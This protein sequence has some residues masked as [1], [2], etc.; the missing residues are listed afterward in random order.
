M[1]RSSVPKFIRGNKL[2][3]GVGDTS[4][5]APLRQP[6]PRPRSPQSRQTVPFGTPSGESHATQWAACYRRGI[7]VSY[8]INMLTDAASFLGWACGAQVA[9]YFANDCCSLRSSPPE[10]TN[11][12]TYTWWGGVGDDGLPSFYHRVNVMLACGSSCPCSGQISRHFSRL[13]SGHPW[14]M[15]KLSARCT[16]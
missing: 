12:A 3:D 1:S 6:P 15:R 10:P 7:K 16:R 11:D 9:C 2:G 4:M 5:W 13:D 8:N 14:C